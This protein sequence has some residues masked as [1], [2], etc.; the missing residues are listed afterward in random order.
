VGSWQSGDE[1]VSDPTPRSRSLLE[2]SVILAVIGLLASS[3]FEGLH[4]TQE[5]TEKLVVESTIRNISTGL[6]NAIAERMFHGQDGKI[7]EL[8]GTNPVIWLEKPPAGY[9]GEF[10]SAQAN[11]PPG[12]WFFDQASK[13]L[14]YR[15]NIDRHLKLEAADGMFGWRVDGISASGGTGS[16]VDS[17]KVTVLTRYQ[18]F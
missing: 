14:R 1:E 3:L 4:Y 7:V 17:V 10:P 2:F 9:L 11:V 13:E 8:V 18:W 12:A 15:P 16:K 6:L 5:Q